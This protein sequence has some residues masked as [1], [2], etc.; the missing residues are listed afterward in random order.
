LA[1]FVTF[2]LL[3]RLDVDTAFQLTAL[4][5]FTAM[6]VRLFINRY[7]IIS[8]SLWIRLI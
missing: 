1:F 2:C 4:V 3:I 8:W 5:S 6:H 7:R